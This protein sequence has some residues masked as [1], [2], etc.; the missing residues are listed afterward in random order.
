MKGWWAAHHR[1]NAE[2]TYYSWTNTNSIIAVPESYPVIS[3][4]N[5]G[6]GFELLS[7]RNIVPELLFSPRPALRQ[8][9]VTNLHR[10]K[11]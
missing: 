11:S 7:H 4:P 10:R 2:N 6:W 9:G 5:Q 3:P 8:Q 1:T